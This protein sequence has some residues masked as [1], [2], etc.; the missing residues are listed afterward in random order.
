MSDL[1]F[2]LSEEGINGQEARRAEALALAQQTFDIQRRVL[3]VEDARTLWAMDMLA[4]A[5]DRSG[6]PAEAEKLQREELDIAGRVQ[7]PDS[8]SALNAL[9]NL[10]GTLIDLGR[11]SEAED[12]LRQTLE[13]DRR[14][15][16]SRDPE[17]GAAGYNLACVIARQGRLDEAFSVLRQAIKTT[18]PKSLL[19]IEKDSDLAPLHDDSRWTEIV[20]LAKQRVA[21][22]E[23]PN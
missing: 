17:T 18:Y 23:K 21:A 9:G 22:A 20:Q 19:M 4:I 2:T 11:Y 7:G 5:L 8:I 3:G 12:V 15:Y 6:R 13:A 14:V 16:G 10:G 1:A